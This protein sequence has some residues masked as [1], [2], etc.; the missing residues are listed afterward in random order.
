MSHFD[1]RQS[2][3]FWKVTFLNESHPESPGHIALF[4][5][6]LVND[7]D[8][9]QTSGMGLRWSCCRPCCW[10]TAARGRRTFYREP[11]PDVCL[12]SMTVASRRRMRCCK[13]ST[14]HSL[15]VSYIL[16]LSHLHPRIRAIRYPPSLLSPSILYLLWHMLRRWKWADLGTFNFFRIHQG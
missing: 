14:A 13:R 1:F 2:K 5:F 9:H 12:M 7:M 4:V 3:A 6:P 11:I 15:S 16:Y 10:G 8:E